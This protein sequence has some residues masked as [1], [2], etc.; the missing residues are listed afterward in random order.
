MPDSIDDVGVGR[1]WDRK[2]LELGEIGIGRE[3]GV[4]RIWGKVS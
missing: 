3:V 2:R 1:G 4:G